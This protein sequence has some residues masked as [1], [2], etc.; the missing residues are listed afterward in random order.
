MQFNKALKAVQSND[1]KTLKK[2]IAKKDFDINA[3]EEEVFIGQLG[4]IVKKSSRS[5]L[6]S[7]ARFLNRD[8]LA[9][10]LVKKG[11]KEKQLVR[12]KNEEGEEKW[13]VPSNKKKK[14]EKK[15]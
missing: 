1:I 5:S 9:D 4:D 3:I 6:L 14:N 12:E 13:V 11:A 2:I 10:Y 7:I 15:V 8:N